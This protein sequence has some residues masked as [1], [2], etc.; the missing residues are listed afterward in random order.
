MN[1]F[2]KTTGLI[3]FWTRVIIFLGTI[4]ITIFQKQIMR[5]FYSPTLDIT[6]FPFED[7]FIT[8]VLLLIVGLFYYKKNINKRSRAIIS[9]YFYLLVTVLFSNPLVSNISAMLTGMKGSEYMVA[10]SV[11]STALQSILYIFVLTSNVCFYLSVGALIVSNDNDNHNKEIE[12]DVSEKSRT[13]LILYSGF[14]G[15]FG[16]DRFYAKRIGTGI[17]KVLLGLPIIITVI[18]IL[19][20]SGSNFFSDPL[21]AFFLTFSY[22]FAINQSDSFLPSILIAIIPYLPI[23]IFSIVDFVL[24]VLGKFKDSDNKLIVKW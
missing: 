14:L 12:T 11:L 3:S 15:I 22:A 21:S 8:F 16:I 6:I 4:L 23:T 9:L 17:V 19:S 5:I 24:C 20:I 1:K 18:R 10:K 2:P 7:V 13:K